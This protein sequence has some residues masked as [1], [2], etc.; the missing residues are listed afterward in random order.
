MAFLSSYVSVFSVALVAMLTDIN[1]TANPGLS[2]L[3]TTHRLNHHYPWN[4]AYSIRVIFTLPHLDIHLCTSFTITVLKPPNFGRLS[5]D[6]FTQYFPLTSIHAASFASHWC[7]HYR[8][9]RFLGRTWMFVYWSRPVA[10]SV[11]VL[12]NNPRAMIIGG[13]Y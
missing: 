4:H 10:C 1:V 8:L 3:S 2:L 5:S 13:Q 11:I 9:Y 6:A 7:S 12:F